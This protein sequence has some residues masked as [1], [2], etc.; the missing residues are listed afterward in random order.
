MK[1][2]PLINFRDLTVWQKA[3]PFVLVVF[4]YTELFLRNEIYE[5]ISQLRRAA[6]SIVA[7]MVK[8]FNSGSWLL[9]SG[10]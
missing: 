8:G 3:Q 6:I 5:L 10:F 4:R 9:N 1:R 2:Q 7:N